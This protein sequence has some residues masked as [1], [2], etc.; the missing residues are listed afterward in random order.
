M[1][2]NG[3]RMGDKISYLHFN[4]LESITHAATSYII[5]A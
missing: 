4:Y 2:E 3:L 5:T 1:H